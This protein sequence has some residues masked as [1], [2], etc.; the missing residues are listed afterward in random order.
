M[1]EG[2]GLF[3][4]PDGVAFRLVYDT[5]VAPAMRSSKL[6]QT[7]IVRVFG[8]ESLLSEVVFWL[9]TAQVIVADL[10]TV[11]A[12]LMLVLGLCLGMHRCP[13]LIAEEPTELPFNLGALRCIYYDSNKEGLVQLRKDLTRAIRIH[14]TASK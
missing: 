3:L 11:N 2:V 14:L 7:K 8:S 10:T 9:Q 5:A 13:L 1:E 4:A 6:N 12:D